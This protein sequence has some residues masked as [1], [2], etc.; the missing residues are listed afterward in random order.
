[1]NTLWRKQDGWKCSDTVPTDETSF[2][3]NAP[4]DYDIPTTTVKRGGIIQPQAT[5]QQNKSN[6][7][8]GAASSSAGR[9]RRHK[10]RTRRHSQVLKTRWVEKSAFEDIYVVGCWYL[11]R[12]RTKK[13]TCQTWPW[14]RREN[15]GCSSHATDRE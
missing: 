3:V 10:H 11:L 7:G 15:P 14:L 9:V 2:L 8:S 12:A 4:L 6:I 1:M 13:E 5:G